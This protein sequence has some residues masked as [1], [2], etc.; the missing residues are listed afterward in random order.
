MSQETI[1]LDQRRKLSPL[2]YQRIRFYYCSQ[3]MT[4]RELSTSFGCSTKYV[5]KILDDGNLQRG[6]PDR[7]GWGPEQQTRT[8]ITWEISACGSC[9]RTFGTSG[10]QDHV[11][12]WTASG[13]QSLSCLSVMP[14]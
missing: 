1:D 5:K 9:G 8:V 10:L 14:S 4:I 11:N 13:T 2:D 3:N 6:G 12:I 7:P